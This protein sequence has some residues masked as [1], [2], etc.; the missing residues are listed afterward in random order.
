M[1]QLLGGRD[2]QEQPPVADVLG[3]QVQADGRL[4]VVAVQHG[5]QPILDRRHQVD[6]LAALL[7]NGAQIAHLLIRHPDAGQEAGR[8]QLGEGQRGFLVVHHARLNNQSHM[9]RMHDRDGMDERLKEIVDL[10]GVRR[11]FQDDRVLAGQVLLSPGFDLTNRDALRAEDRLFRRRRRRSPAGTPC[12]GRD[13]SSALRL[14]L[15]WLP[16]LLRSAGERRA[17]PGSGPRLHT[18][19]RACRSGPFLRPRQSASQV[20]GIER[21]SQTRKRACPS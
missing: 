8:V 11:H 18:F 19:H 12:A 5:M 1:T 15:P 21:A 13:R 6:V 14:T 16:L 20:G 7:D 2:R 17:H 4:D 10:P 9:R 3:K